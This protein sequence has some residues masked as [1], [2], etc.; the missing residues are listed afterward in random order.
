MA[1]MTIFQYYGHFGHYWSTQYGHKY[2]QPMID[3]E[4]IGKTKISCEN[5]FEKYARGKNWEP[6]Q[7]FVG[8]EAIFN[9][10]L[11]SESLKMGS[12]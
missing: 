7:N 8:L 12:L 11:G 3:Y 9:V 2:G 6:K 1:N 10:F 5:G 4:C